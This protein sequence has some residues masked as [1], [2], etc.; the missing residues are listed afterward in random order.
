M[1]MAIALAGITSMQAPVRDQFHPGYHAELLPG[2]EILP[3]KVH[4]D[5]SNYWQL[6]AFRIAGCGCL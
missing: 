6:L 1:R 5:S 3:I 4:L 2:V